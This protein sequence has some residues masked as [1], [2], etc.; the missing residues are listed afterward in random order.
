MLMARLDK[1]SHDEMKTLLYRYFQK[2]PILYDY[3]LKKDS[4]C[5]E[6]SIKTLFSMHRPIFETLT[7]QTEKMKIVHSPE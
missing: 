1:L 4:C 3:K 5:K 7:Y 2:V 6:P